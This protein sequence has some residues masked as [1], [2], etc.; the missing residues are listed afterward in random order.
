MCPLAILLGVETCSICLLPGVGTYSIGVP[1]GVGWECKL[2]PPKFRD[3]VQLMGGTLDIN[4]HY[5]FNLLI[6]SISVMRLASSPWN[7]PVL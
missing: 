4:V 2:P 6:Y 1:P 5:L 7:H 3:V